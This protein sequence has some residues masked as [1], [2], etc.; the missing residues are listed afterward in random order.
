MEKLNKFW[1]GVLFGVILPPI[2]L[3]IIYLTLTKTLNFT[4]FLN[5]LK[6]RNLSTSLYIWA[7]IPVFFMFAFFY[8]KKYDS[9]SK[10]IVLP[11]MLYT[12][13]LVI[14]NF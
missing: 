12:F 3:V 7:I 6:S 5:L 4:E 9:A 10:G 8:F 2:S 14:L 11:T 1:V 13:T